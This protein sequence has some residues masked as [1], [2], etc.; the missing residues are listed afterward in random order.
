MRNLIGL[1]LGVVMLSA[2]CGST[3]VRE[4]VTNSGGVLD[5]ASDSIQYT[6]VD[7]DVSRPGAASPVDAAAVFV[8]GEFTPDGTPE[9]ESEAGSRAVVLVRDGD[10]NRVGRVLMIRHP[11]GWHVNAIEGC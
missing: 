5:C 7:S 10:G 3:E 9:V 4:V 1:V 2:A 11:S 6:M 8:G